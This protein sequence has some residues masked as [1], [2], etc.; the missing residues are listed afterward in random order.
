MKKFSCVIT[1]LLTTGLLLALAGPAAAQ[2][3]YP[4]R[5][6]RIIS[7]Y[8]AGGGNSIM[9][10]LIG[11][12]LTE[13]WGQQVIVDSRPGGNT[14]I[15]TE[16]T[17]K[18]TPDGYTVLLAGSSHVLVPLVLKT[19]YGPIKD[20]TAIAGVAKYELILVTNPSLP[21][22]NL[23]EL[24][25]LAKSKPGQLNY[26]TW[27]SGSVSHLGME[28]LSMMTGIHM[29][30]IPYKGTAPALMDVI[31]GHA[32]LFLSTPSAP[33]PQIKA[34]KL[35]AIAVCG[36]SRSPAVPDVPTFAESGLPD[37]KPR[38]WYGIVAPAGV[39]K[40]IVDKMSAEIGRI[41]AMPDTREKLNAQG[42]EPRFLNPEQ[43][44]ALMKSDIA[45]WE[46]VIKTANI[47]LE[48]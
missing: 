48:N 38:S 43:F 19:P 11:Q 15:G 31:G 42:V 45:L 4:Y 10:R 23:K 3:P 14:I 28:L 46:K 36:E 1:R 6:I 29:V 24:I 40:A 33:I 22:N 16:A 2:Q 47:K 44:A 32:D 26:V 39:P 25:A 20:F 30:H 8:A 7:P 21:A 41:I 18:A 37:F 34:G 5:P 35:K 9:A 12:K 27:G 13:A 17:V